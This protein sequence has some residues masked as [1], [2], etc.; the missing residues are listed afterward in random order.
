MTAVS[1]D[2][3]DYINL[4]LYDVDPTTLVDRMILNSQLL[5]PGWNPELGVDEVTIA[6]GLALEVAELVFAVN[7]LPPAIMQ[8]LL[9]LFGIT[10]GAGTPATATVTFQTQAPAATSIP[11]GTQLQLVLGSKSYIFETTADIPVAAGTASVTGSVQC[12]TNAAA[13]NGSAAGTNLTVLGFVSPVSSAA[14]ATSPVGGTDPETMS[15][16]L[17]RGGQT[18]QSISS[19][20]SLPAQFT[21]AAL[22]DTADGVFR[23]WTTSNWDPTLSGG[24]GAT[25][26]GSVTVSAMGQGGTMLTGPQQASLLA[27]LQAGA[28]AGLAVHVVNPNVTVVPVTCTVWQEPGYT[29]SQVQANVAAQLAAS[30]ASGGAGLSTDLWPFTQP[31]GAL[32]SLVHLNNLI[33]VITD[34]PG[35]AFV[36]AMTAPSAD[37]NL[38]GIAPLAT[39]GTVTVFV[40]GP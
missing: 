20:L 11:Q 23:A 13:V 24:A 22:A 18:L 28:L 37:V 34:T 38:P 14:L 5:L 3:T 30:V 21:D 33:S 40:E 32:N 2:I 12:T 7:R 6:Q 27:K 17:N 4:T 15:A 29:V 39:L 1:P 36:V 19:A 26:Q 35:V 9:Q 16:W 25:A 10:R 31:N 8:A